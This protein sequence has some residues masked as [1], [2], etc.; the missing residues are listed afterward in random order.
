MYYSG[1]DPRT[2]KPV[3]TAK[4]PREKAMQRALLQWARPDKRALVLE[5]L[6][7]AGREDLVGYGKECLIAPPPGWKPSKPERP[8]AKKRPPQQGAKPRGWARAKKK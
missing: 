3:Y 4:T 1:L 6:R 7:E 2:M 5:A 8:H